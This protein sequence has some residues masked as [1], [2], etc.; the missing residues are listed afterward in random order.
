MAFDMDFKKWGIAGLIIGL[1]A[2][3]IQTFIIAKLPQITVMFATVDVRDKFVSG[4][5]P[6]L[7]TSLFGLI[8]GVQAPNLLVMLAGAVILTILG[9]LIARFAYP[10]FIGEGRTMRWA[11]V[12]FYGYIAT[13]LLLAVLGGKFSFGMILPMLLNFGT[14]AFAIYALII[15]AVVNWLYENIPPLQKQVPSLPPN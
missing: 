9:A 10:K 6:G 15:G 11:V 13:V 12:I 14:V 7:G 3:A 5:G 2:W 1:L 8:K 4:L